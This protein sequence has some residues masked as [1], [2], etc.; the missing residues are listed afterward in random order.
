MLAAAPLK[1]S[2]LAAIAFTAATLEPIA[3]L[4]P[5][6]S[7]LNPLT[8]GGRVHDSAAEVQAAD[9]LANLRRLFGHGQIV[10]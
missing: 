5:K 10:F 9:A 1:P 2:T 7:R 8:P 4:Q 6:C 3:F